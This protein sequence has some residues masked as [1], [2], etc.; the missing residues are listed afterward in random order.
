MYL[1]ASIF[2]RGLV[3]GQF[4][5]G[6]NLNRVAHQ[7]LADLTRNETIDTENME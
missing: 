2:A 7:L 5:I 6:N 4:L 1:S 3:L